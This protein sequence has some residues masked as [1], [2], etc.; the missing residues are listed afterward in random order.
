MRGNTS[1]QTIDFL[2]L[3]PVLQYMA[4]LGG[5][6][7]GGALLK[8]VFAVLAVIII[9]FFTVRKKLFK[10]LEWWLIW[11]FS[12]GFF[13]GQGFIKTELIT[14]YAAKPTF[15]L[16]MIAVAFFFKI[17]PA[18]K[19]ARFILI[20]MAYLLIA[21]ISLVYHKQSPFV[22]ITASAFFFVYLL[23]RSASLQPRECKKLL[24]LLIAAA[25]FQTFICVL[26]VAQI[27]PPSTRMMDDGTGD[28]FEWTAGLDDVA[29][30]TF[31][32]VAGHIV[33]WYA[34][35][36][37][38]FCIL[39]WT[40]TRKRKYLFATLLALLQF[41]TVDSKT[42]MGVMLVMMVFLFRH[43]W[44]NR[45]GFR[46]PAKKMI[47]FGISA[48]VMGYF[49]FLGWNFYYEYQH[50]AGGTE[51]RGNFNDVYETEIKK[52]QELIL[53]NISDWGKIRGFQYV[54]KDFTAN[55]DFQVL[56][57]YSLQGYSYNG[58]MSQI[59][60]N[61]TPLMRLN[62]FTRSRSSLIT[63][64]A[65]N[66]LVGFICYFAA[67]IAWYRYNTRKTVSN[68]LDKVIRSLTK[69]FFVF[70]II[71]A[72]IYDISFTTIPL[73]A[74]SAVTALLKRLSAGTQSTSLHH[75]VPGIVSKV[76]PV[77]AIAS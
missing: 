24:N 33:S 41:A 2:R 10:A 37:A 31:G 8:D 14:K 36:I 76:N 54:M 72:F 69:I 56:W 50:K 63:L 16:F 34:S 42:I 59:E 6:L 64:F 19:K 71:A 75:Y 11:C 3:K 5:V 13:V 49:L 38:V 52:S 12:Y 20:W 27:I 18:V 43:L 60:S 40:I 29:C 51:S 65:Q 45:N 74:F 48:V 9:I 73:L 70:T 57:G 22:L 32:P 55:D 58:K 44:V 68:D 15:L 25:L 39:I 61:D 67:M 77:P 4:L 7:I 28:Q 23:F 1:I 21:L 62:N 17:P 66:G 46:L 30:G 26:Q 53:E 35:F 47:S